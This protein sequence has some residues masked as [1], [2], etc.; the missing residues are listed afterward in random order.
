VTRIG[1]AIHILKVLKCD[2]NYEVKQG[3]QGELEIWYLASE[4]K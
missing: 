4:N 2:Q 1:D 3:E